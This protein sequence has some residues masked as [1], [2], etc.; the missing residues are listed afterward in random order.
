MLDVGVKQVGFGIQITCQLIVTTRQIFLQ[1]SDRKDQVAN[2][3][4]QVV[5]Q[6]TKDQQRRLLIP[7]VIH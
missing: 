2:Q 5:P 6:G 1:R 3:R 7:G 4:Q